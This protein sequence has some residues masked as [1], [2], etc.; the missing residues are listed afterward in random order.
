MTQ[1]IG[2]L[3]G[4]LTTAS[5][6]PQ[7]LKVYKTRL[8]RDVSLAWTGMLTVGIFFWLMYGLILRDIP[9]I[10][11]NVSGFIFSLAVLIGKMM[12]RKYEK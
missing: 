10:F 4:V 8:T 12:Y 1:Y 9:L 6:V 7:V 2:L 3:A 11:A 5:L